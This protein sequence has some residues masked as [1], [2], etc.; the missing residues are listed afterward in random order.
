MKFLLFQAVI[1]LIFPVSKKKVSWFP[2][3]HIW[4]LA[5][6]SVG[7]WTEECEKWFQSHVSSIHSGTF[8][9]RSSTEWR[10]R[11]RST[12]AAVKVTY[13][14]KMGAASFISAH[15]DLLSRN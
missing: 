15:H 4:N 11:L 5:G 7:Q 8:Q 10:N 1:N 3:S 13:Q 2:P 6:Y 9:P 14:M 12:R